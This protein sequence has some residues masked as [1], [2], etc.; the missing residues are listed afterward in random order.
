MTHA[1]T[2]GPPP[3]RP[4]SAEH[5]PAWPSSA[6][7]PPAWPSSAGPSS[8][9]RGDR[10]FPGRPLPRA[11]HVLAVTARPG[12]ESAD[13]GALLYAFR[14]R[15]SSLALL[16]LTRG[17]ASPVNSTRERLENIR[18]WELQVAAGLLGIT[19]LAV[20]DYADGTL[21]RNPLAELTERVRRAIRAHA[22]DLLLVIE[23]AGGDPDDTAVARAAC[24]AAEQMGV[25]VLA[26]MPRPARYGWP[27]DLG[28]A[29]A[30]ACLVQRAAVA[31]HASQAAAYASQARASQAAASQARASQAAEPRPDHPDHREQLRWLIPPARD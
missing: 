26:R 29:A 9:V 2:I 10:P 7:H 31:A 1:A 17:E 24:A 5:P 28:P 20:A 14:R 27:V 13:L 18:P 8:A 30:T 11:A 22:A 15:G 3:A 25:P 12:Q 6:G 21:H 16:T 4:S 19:S 23:P